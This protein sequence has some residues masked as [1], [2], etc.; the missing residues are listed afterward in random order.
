MINL[1]V[2]M[3]KMNKGNVNDIKF[4]LSLLPDWARSI[5]P[6]LDPTMYGTGS[7]KG[8]LKVVKRVQEIK[9]RLSLELLS[10]Y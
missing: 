7:Y 4:L 2:W 1:D 9:D 5:E 6:G 8:D 10:G 3:H